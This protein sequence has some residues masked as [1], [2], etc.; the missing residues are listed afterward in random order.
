MSWLSKTRAAA[1]LIL[2]LSIPAFA[3]D[4]AL[5]LKRGVQEI[6][7]EVSPDQAMDFMRHVY[8][9]DRWF[10]YPKFQETTAYL[11]R[12]MG[13]IG[14]KNVEVLG[15]PADGVS[16]F[17]F[18]TTPLAWDAKSGRLEIIEPLAPSEDRVL[19]D[20]Q[21]IPAVSRLGPSAASGS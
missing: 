4:P 5:E 13:D 16:Q 6:G 18:W 3:A 15:A 7:S 10:T 21:K 17:G 11:N 9:S 12:T 8:A 20:Y 2:A 19:A 14:L 1:L